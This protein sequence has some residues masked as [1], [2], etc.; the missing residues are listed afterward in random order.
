ME[1]YREKLL[2]GFQDVLDNYKR[3][4]ED[5]EPTVR[6]TLILEGCLYKLDKGFDWLFGK[7]ESYDDTE[8]F[9][10][11]MIKDKLGEEILEGALPAMRDVV[12]A[13]ITDIIEC[14]N[15]R[16]KM[17]EKIDNLDKKLDAVLLGPDYKDGREM[18]NNAS[19]DFSSHL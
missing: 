19:N 5:H 8:K 3:L 12:K 6:H 2:S 4:Q 11:Q 16:K 15:D 18:M 13:E 10:L 17:E 14:I 1:N 9:L 7:A